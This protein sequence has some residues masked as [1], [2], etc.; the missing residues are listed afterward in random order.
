MNKFYVDDKEEVL[1]ADDGF[2]K[3]YENGFIRNS[4]RYKKRVYNADY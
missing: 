4:K 3:F 1:L 2:D